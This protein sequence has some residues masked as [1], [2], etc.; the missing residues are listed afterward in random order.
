MCCKFCFILENFTTN[1]TRSNLQQQFHIS[2]RPKV[3][4]SNI[5]PA[6]SK[7]SESGASLFKYKLSNTETVP[8]QIHCIICGRSTIHLR[9]LK[10]Q[11]FRS[12]HNFPSLR[13][14]CSATI[15]C[16]SI[17]VEYTFINPSRW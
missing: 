9:F 7:I 10:A 8:Y 15:D 17:V 5:L 4:C 3:S 16:S 6:S 14:P 12:H 2:C 1:L 11:N 13:D